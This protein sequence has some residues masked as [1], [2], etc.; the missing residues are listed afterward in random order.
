MC[1]CKV[2]AILIWQTHN[3]ADA[4]IFPVFI[5]PQHK[6]SINI[7]FWTFFPPLQ[8]HQWYG[9]RINLLAVQLDRKLRSNVNR[10]LIPSQLIIG[11]RTIRS[12]HQ[13]IHVRKFKVTR[14]HLPMSALFKWH[15]NCS[16]T[17]SDIWRRLKNWSAN[18]LNRKL[19]K[20]QI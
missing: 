13:V 2:C 16:R 14:Q 1:M 6:S 11:W 8:F 18:L 17:R 19:N 3:S 15:N 12:L 4:S 9:F 20:F 7:S 5:P 10:R